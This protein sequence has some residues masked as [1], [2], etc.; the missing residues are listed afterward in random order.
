[1]LFLFE[2]SSEYVHTTYLNSDAF[3][4]KSFYPNNSRPNFKL[5]QTLKF[6]LKKSTSKL[7]WIL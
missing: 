5:N 1:M 7:H 6:K 3:T 4:Q 2:I